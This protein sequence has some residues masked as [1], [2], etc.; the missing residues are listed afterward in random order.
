MEGLRKRWT[1]YRNSW[2]VS[3][4]YAGWKAEELLRDKVITEEVVKNA[5]SE[6]SAQAD[7]FSDIRGSA[8][9]KRHLVGVLFQRSFDIA[10]KRALG[11]EVDTLHF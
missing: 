8:K 4:E 5:A 6:T 11:E 9:Y 1:D 10:L 2:P 7:P 3:Q